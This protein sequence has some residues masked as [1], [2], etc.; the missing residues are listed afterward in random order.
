[1]DISNN[2]HVIILTETWLHAGIGTGEQMD[3]RYVVYRK[4]RDY[5]ATNQQRGGGKGY[6]S[7]LKIIYLVSAYSFWKKEIMGSN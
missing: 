2:D 7:E 1:M 3:N 6:L 5:D 4:D